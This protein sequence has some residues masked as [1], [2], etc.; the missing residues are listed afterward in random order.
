MNTHLRRH[1]EQGRHTWGVFRI[2][3]STRVSMILDSLV[4]I[5]SAS[6][7]GEWAD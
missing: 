6:E 4:L 5:W 2:D 7:A 3:S 1:L